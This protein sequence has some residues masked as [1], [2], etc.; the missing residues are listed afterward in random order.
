MSEHYIGINFVCPKC[1][2]YH[3]FFIQ[4][5]IQA[6][7]QARNHTQHHL[8]L[9]M[10]YNPM[11]LTILMPFYSTDCT[12]FYLKCTLSLPIEVPSQN[13]ALPSKPWLDS[14]FFQQKS[15]LFLLIIDIYFCYF[16]QY[17]AC[18]THL[19]SKDTM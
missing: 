15:C 10:L 1:A 19:D 17:R 18:S 13:T 16:W 6:K 12:V 5:C 11:S 9:N 8:G 3:Q 4:V 2:H 14:H 7:R